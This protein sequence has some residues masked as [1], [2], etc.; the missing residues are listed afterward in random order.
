M[1]KG[2][3]TSVWDMGQEVLTAAVLDEETG[4]ITTESVDV[5]DFDLE[6]LIEETFTSID[7]VEYKVCPDCHEYVMREKCI[8][9]EGNG[10]DYDGQLICSDPYCESNLIT[11]YQMTREKAISDLVDN[12]IQTIKEGIESG[13][14]SY[15]NDIMCGGFQGYEQFTGE[16]LINEYKETLGKDIELMAEDELDEVIK[17]ECPVSQEQFD[18]LK[19]E[20][21]TWEA[22]EK[23]SAREKAMAW[24]NSLMTFQRI[25]LADVYY[26]R[27][28][29]GLTGRE[30]EF[31]FNH[32]S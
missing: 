10:I 22:D 9:G 12:D 20:F 17:Y 29:E 6:I 5:E 23:Q 26:S 13:D 3:F 28:P 27:S 32:K 24:W 15:I 8:E 16:E 2:T 18:S 4:R 14:N 21:D 25:L 11:V 31:L 1:I 30:I 7:G 19:A